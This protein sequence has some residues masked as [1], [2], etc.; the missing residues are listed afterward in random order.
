M[1]KVSARIRL[2]TADDLPAA[3]RLACEAGWNQI[4]ADWRRFLAMQPD[5]C[6]VAEHQG[7]CVGTVVA[8]M[9]DQVAW[10][11]MLLVDIAQRGQG[12]GQALIEH[13]LAFLDEQR[14]AT[15]RLDATPLGQPLYEKLGFRP[16]F[17]LARYAGVLP[18]A[19]DDALGEKRLAA[20]TA[21]R[22]DI[23][24]IVNLDRG[25]TGTDRRQFLVRL[26]DEKP[27]PLRVV[28]SL[29]EIAGYMTVRCGRCASQLGPCLGS[30]DACPALLADAATTLAGQT[31]FVDVPMS[32]SPAV[33]FT[34]SVGLKVQRTFVRM[35]RG[36]AV[37]EDIARLWAS[38]G[39]E[40]G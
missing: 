36:R 2:M 9:F 35:C 4:E 38:S 20:R 26:F 15:V 29:G 3:M 6:F 22:P 14:I 17:E 33:E 34:Q 5:G 18:A 28:E 19:V 13:A 25:I 39:P 24:R 30:A 11:A 23:E 32:N 12:F 8:C 10:I 16:Q 1:S 40:L 21:Q 27:D 37:Q 7:G 31:V